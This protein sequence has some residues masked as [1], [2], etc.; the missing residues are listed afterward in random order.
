[1]SLALIGSATPTSVTSLG[2]RS[3]GGG[4]R[5]LAMTAPRASIKLARRWTACRG[6]E[7][8]SRPGGGR[9][10]LTRASHSGLAAAWRTLSES[11]EVR[12]FRGT[13]QTMN[14]RYPA[15]DSSVLTSRAAWLCPLS[16]QTKQQVVLPSANSLEPIGQLALKPSVRIGR[17][18]EVERGPTQRRRV[19][20]SLQRVFVGQAAR[21]SI[22]VSCR[23]HGIVA[24]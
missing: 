1:M 4:T 24:L 23:A 12:S 20:K 13:V 2:P 3:C 14:E 6:E 16:R 22:E 18:V 21:D 11:T 17:F 7:R 5:A 15:I 8:K 9:F 19:S 10:V